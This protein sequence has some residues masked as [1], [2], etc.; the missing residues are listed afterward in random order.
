MNSKIYKFAGS[1]GRYNESLAKNVASLYL[2]QLKRQISIFKDD[3][4]V[5]YHLTIDV[6]DAINML[7]VSDSTKDSLRKFYSRLEKIYVTIGKP[8]YKPSSAVSVSSAFFQPPDMIFVTLNVGVETYNDLRLILSDI[9]NQIVSTF[10]H[11]IE[12]YAQMIPVRLKTLR[13]YDAEFQNW[14]EQ[15]QEMLN[16]KYVPFI[17][18]IYG[19]YADPTEIGAYVSSLYMRSKELRIKFSDM[20]ENHFIKRVEAQMQRRLGK[21]PDAATMIEGACK[22]LL[23]KYMEYARSRYGAQVN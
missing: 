18:D 17:A 19:Y 16:N 6:A 10:R 5:A 14:R 3:D 21:D 9:R 11:E 4:F 1:L 13:D 2:S 8:S 20:L 15:H 22:R 7:Q 12:H 23:A